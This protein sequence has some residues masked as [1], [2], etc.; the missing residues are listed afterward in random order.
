[1]R[2]TRQRELTGHTFHEWRVLDF[3]HANNFNKQ[4]WNCVCTCGVEKK[5]ESYNLTSGRSKSCRKCSSKVVIETV[6]TKHGKSRS[7]VYRRWLAMKTR[8][9]N[10]KAEKSYRY[11][12][13]LG[14][15]VADVWRNDFQA[16]YDYIGEPPTSLHT[17]DRIDPF[18]DYAPGNV[19]WATQSEQRS[20]LR[21]HVDQLRCYA[22]REQRTGKKAPEPKLKGNRFLWP[23]LN[24]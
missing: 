20:N 11:H 5:V 4:Y 15:K 22:E 3:S 16:F 14:V 12:G 1:M 19:R 18:G 2:I 24:R 23:I 9:Y 7:L 8:C 21:V 13:A 10:E 17:V 6:I